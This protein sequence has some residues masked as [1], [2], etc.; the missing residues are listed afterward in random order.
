MDDES[1][2]N[3]ENLLNQMHENDINSA[4][5]REDGVLIYSTFSLEDSAVN[6]ISTV[7]N[8]SDAIIRMVNDKQKEIEITLNGISF[9]I[10]NIDTFMLCS[11]LKNKEKKSTV[12]EYATK[13]APYVK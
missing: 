11:V 5:I 2:K 13:I 9:F 6:I 1:K 3:I 12:R 4:L 8:T 10:V 7:S